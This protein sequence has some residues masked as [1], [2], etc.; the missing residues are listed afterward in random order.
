MKAGLIL[1]LMVMCLGDSTSQTRGE[2][3]VFFSASVGTVWMQSSKFNEVCNT[4]LLPHFGGGLG[5]AISNKKYLYARFAYHSQKG[6]IAYY[7]NPSPIGGSSSFRYADVTFDELVV[8]GGLEFV[9][10][11]TQALD[12]GLII[13]LAY[14]HVGEGAL[15][16]AAKSVDAL[17]CR[18][19]FFVELP[20]ETI[21]SSLSLEAGVLLTLS[22]STYSGNEFG[23][24]DVSLTYRAYFGK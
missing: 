2:K 10:I 16:L 18:G 3:P 1:F 8:D 12:F 11:T 21:G 14:V 7:D 5:F 13:G 17:A 6:T 23:G 9:T 15:S 22:A 19:S 24:Y 20:F 4:R